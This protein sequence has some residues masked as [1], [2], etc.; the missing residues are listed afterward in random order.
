MPEFDVA[1]GVAMLAV[2]FCYSCM[3]DQVVDPPQT[4]IEFCFAFHLA[5]FLL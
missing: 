2:I 5:T 3:L 4:A 1:K